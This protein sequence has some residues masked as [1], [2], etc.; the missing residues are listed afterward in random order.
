M[1]KFG[2]FEPD[3]S[4]VFARYGARLRLPYRDA[5]TTIDLDIGIV[6]RIEITAVSKR[7]LIEYLEGIEQEVKKALAEARNM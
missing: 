3:N 2:T 1:K 6:E 7:A 5:R 4:G